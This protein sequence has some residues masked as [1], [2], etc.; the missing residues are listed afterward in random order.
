MLLQTHLQ[1]S[2]ELCL[3]NNIFIFWKYHT[4]IQRSFLSITQKGLQFNYIIICI[5]TH[6]YTHI[7]MQVYTCTYIQR[8]TYVHTHVQIYT[9][10]YI[11]IHICTYIYMLTQIH[12]YTQIY[13]HI[14][15]IHSSSD[16]HD[17]PRNLD[18]VLRWKVHRNLVSWNR[19]IL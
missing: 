7:C 15:Y 13:I 17:R 19:G 6:I 1:N 16:P 12:K 8:D 9:H 4:C 10:L 5:Y 14:C 2:Q 18:I 11:Q 3:L